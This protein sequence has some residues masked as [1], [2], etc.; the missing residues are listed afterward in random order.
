MLKK[1]FYARGLFWALA[2]ILFA[3]NMIYATLHP[4][5]V[6]NIF[7]ALSGWISGIATVILGIIAY[8]QNAK[9]EEANT[10]Y[11]NKQQ[12]LLEDTS[13]EN[14]AQNDFL[15]RNRDYQE[16]Y[17][18]LGEL[19]QLYNNMMIEHTP[20]QMKSY[21]LCS[22]EKYEDSKRKASSCLVQIYDYCETQVMHFATIARSI[23][24]NQ[25][26]FDH[27][28]DIVIAVDAYIHH[29]RFLNDRCI[30]PSMPLEQFVSDNYLGTPLIECFAEIQDLIA[31]LIREVQQLIFFIVDETNDYSDVKKT[32]KELRD[33]NIT[34]HKEIDEIIAADKMEK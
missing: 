23:N 11:L 33:K 7:T 3:A 9:Y 17:D 30:T 2:S 26:G 14:K 16:L 1:P 19:K 15:I 22:L 25:Y 21:I 24:I 10:T 28:K 13:K 4:A 5:E 29:I 6:P 12:R 32:L 31:G 8:S 20:F 34:I 27:K 18:Y